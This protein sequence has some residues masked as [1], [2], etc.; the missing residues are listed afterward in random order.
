[1]NWLKM[2]H[3]KFVSEQ[4]KKLDDAEREKANQTRDSSSG[5]EVNIEE[6]VSKVADMPIVEEEEPMEQEESAQGD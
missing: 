3:T 4:K 6:S 2:N 1:M 5:G